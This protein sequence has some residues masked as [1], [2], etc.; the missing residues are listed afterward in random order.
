MIL[1]QLPPKLKYRFNPQLLYDSIKA[2]ISIL[3]AKSETSSKLEE[4]GAENLGIF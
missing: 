1:Q 2:V 4:Y 3:V